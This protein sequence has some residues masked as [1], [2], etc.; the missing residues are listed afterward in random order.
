MRIDIRARRY[1]NVMGRDGLKESIWG[2]YGLDGKRDVV[3]Y[4][5]P[6]TCGGGVGGGLSVDVLSATLLAASEGILR[7][8][9]RV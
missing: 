4:E 7:L 8:S 6:S 5:D 1:G 9:K 3:R 2:Q